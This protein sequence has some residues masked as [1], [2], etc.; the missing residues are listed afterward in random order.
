MTKTRFNILGFYISLMYLI[1]QPLMFQNPLDPRFDG[2]FGLMQVSDF[3]VPFMGLWILY[4]LFINFKE[5]KLASLYLDFKWLIVPILFFLFSIFISGYLSEHGIVFS[6]YVKFLYLL[7]LMI[8]FSVL[9]LEDKLIIR[10]VNILLYSTIILLLISLIGYICAVVLDKSNELAQVKFGFPYFDKIT[11]LLGPMKPT[12]KLFGMYLLVILLPFFLN[13]NYFNVY[14]FKLFIALT[15]L[16]SF[17]TFGRVGFITSFLCCVVYLLSFHKKNKQSLIFVLIFFVTFF[18]F[19]TFITIFHFNFTNFNLICDIP[20]MIDNQ[21]QYFG[22]FKN[23]NMCNFQIFSNIT[24]SSY[25]LLKLAA[26]DA[27][28]Q[29][30]FFGIGLSQFSNHWIESAGINIPEF[31]KDYP[32]PMSQSTFLTL[33]AE[34]GLFGLLAW[35]YLIGSYFYKISF[36]ITSSINKYFLNIW[37]FFC[38]LAL[39]DLDIHYF[40][41]IYSLIPLTLVL[42][43]YQNY[44]K[45]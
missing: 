14:L 27:W 22:W 19:I 34:I 33:L 42:S 26:I 2:I 39:I 1:L 24:F 35:I 12:S 32:F 28:L 36:N 18:I 6:S 9:K 25:F 15:F 13:R 31:Y 3:I 37:L 11:R 17:L 10:L 7:T 4:F 5:K 29:S 8:F 43:Y 40:R 23:N 41:F 16:C 30:P 21:T 44:K 20:Y 45:K 38:L